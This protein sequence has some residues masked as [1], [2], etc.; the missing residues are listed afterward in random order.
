MRTWA[1]GRVNLIGE[2]TDYTGGLTLPMAIQLG[3]TVEYEPSSE[4]LIR[5]ESDQDPREAWVRLPVD[6]LRPSADASWVRFVA[7]VAAQVGPAHGGRGRVR[8]T[9]PL[10]AGLSSS[11]A[12]EVALALALGFRGSPLE[13]A[14]ACQRAEHAAIGVPSGIMDQLASVAGR[15]GHAL[16]MDCSSLA[17]TPVPFPEGYEVVAL[18]SGV[19]RRLASSAY[20]ERRSECRAAEAVIG[21]LRFAS[22]EDLTGLADPLLRRRA[23]HVITENARVEEAAAA[24]GRGDTGAFGQLMDA[25]HASLSS[26]FGVSTPVLDELASWLRSQPGV[27]GARLTGAGFGGCVVALAESG[28]VDRWFPERRHPAWRL[29]PAGGATSAP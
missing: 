8:S 22:P 7:A 14:L 1:P 4:P 23:R 12:L 10:G 2:H 29:V 15:A 27:A 17:T 16:L 25:S 3:T 19:R 21:P 6:G 24:L 28:G 5:L 20:A 26:D 18:D 9:V 11:A 13:L